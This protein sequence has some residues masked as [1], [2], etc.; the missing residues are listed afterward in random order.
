VRSGTRQA[1]ED[2]SVWA[3]PPPLKSWKCYLKW[4][5]FLRR[6]AQTFLLTAASLLLYG[7]GCGG[8]SAPLT[9][10]ST[11][12]GGSSGTPGSSAAGGS[13][14]S[15]TSGGG[16]TTSSSSGGSTSG[17]TGTATGGA[18]NGLSTA[19]AFTP[20]TQVAA[21]AQGPCGDGGQCYVSTSAGVVI[22]DF[23]LGSLSCPEVTDGGLFFG[24]FV[25]LAFNAPSGFSVDVGDYPILAPDSSPQSAY[26]NVFLLA[27]DPDGGGRSIAVS[28]TGDLQITQIQPTLAGSFTSA[29]T[30]SSDGG[31]F[32]TLSGSFNANWCSPTP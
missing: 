16:A 23:S 1:C 13:S 2:S 28:A 29:L 25:L 10:L 22:G 15:V 9:G 7:A 24:Q 6:R 31:A 17:S 21:E 32:G 3:T 5:F 14:G 27:V 19:G 8:A 11:S 30:L 26:A 12:T 20:N 18:S 4:M